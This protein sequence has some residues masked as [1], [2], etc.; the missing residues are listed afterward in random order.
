MKLALSSPRSLAGIQGQMRSINFLTTNCERR[1]WMPTGPRR[2]APWA[3]NELL[4][5]FNE[6]LK[7]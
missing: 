3:A 6:A 7:N 5:D 4:N 1:Q 2:C